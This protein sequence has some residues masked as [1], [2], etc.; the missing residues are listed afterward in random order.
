VHR[1]TCYVTE[2]TRPILHV[3]TAKD[4][5]VGK[6]ISVVLESSASPVAHLDIQKSDASTTII[7]VQHDGTVTTLS[8]DLRTVVAGEVKLQSSEPME[9]MAASVVSAKHAQKTILSARSDLLSNL[10]SDSAILVTLSESP[11]ASTL[12][13]NVTY[14]ACTIDLGRKRQLQGKLDVQQ[15]FE[16][17]LSR[18]S[19]TLDARDS[20]ILAAKFSNRETTLDIRLSS[21]FLRFDLQ[22]ASPRP[23]SNAKRILD[24]SSDTVPLSRS[25]VLAVYPDA[26]RLVDVNY[27]TRQSGVTMSAKRRADGSVAARK[28]EL[29]CYS[30]GIGRVLARDHQRLLAVDVAVGGQS[31]NLKM[32]VSTLAQNIGRGSSRADGVPNMLNTIETTV[33]GAPSVPLPS[34]WENNLQGLITDGNISDFENIVIRSF[35]LETPSGINTSASLPHEVVHFVL[36]RMFEYQPPEVAGD[37]PSLSLRFIPQRLL[38][39]LC[40]LGLLRHRTL[41]LCLRDQHRSSVQ[42]LPYTEVAEVLLE[43]DPSLSLLEVYARHLDTPDA[44]ERVYILRYLLRRVLD[45]SVDVEQTGLLTA[46]T[47]EDMEFEQQQLDGVRSNKT[48][49][50]E[51]L[52]RAVIA[53]IERFGSLRQSMISEKL[54]DAFTKTDIFSLVQL[55]RQQLFKAGYTGFTAPDSAASPELL[56][57]S[58]PAAV[59][60]LSGCIDA[61]GPLDLIGGDEEDDLES[62]IPD[63]LSEMTL[64]TQYIEES[65][66]LQGIL[67]ETL[68]YAES[69]ET[70]TSERKAITDKSDDPRRRGEI[71]TLYAQRTEDEDINGMPSAL[72]LSLRVED[73][74]APTRKRKGGG[75]VRERSQREILMLQHR[76]K[77]PYSFERLVL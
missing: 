29:I 14:C 27:S 67:R 5:D 28:V 35:N 42:W 6:P 31:N 34:G 11:D 24:D 19:P 45:E 7:V 30:A 41:E 9:I 3:V 25:H 77:G 65:A 4:K 58:L 48:P 26:L 50:L 43:A 13:K 37:L 22:T 17:N 10:E 57:V 60:I 61:C 32:P 59:K 66:D 21:G 75:Q 70:A 53:T 16:H 54:R 51:A 18:I 68:R 73:A 44:P 64:A 47:A 63:L 52:E 33:G 38:P 2:G 40:A 56:F 8:D 39:I 55:L 46:A 15:L 23:I 71:V 1:Q 72:P 36:D 20:V 12:S 74:I 76:Q 69:Q 49:A 62:I